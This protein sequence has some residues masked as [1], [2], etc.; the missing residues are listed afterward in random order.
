MSVV[1]R[2]PNHPIV[3]SLDKDRRV[4]VV[5]QRGDWL[6]VVLPAWAAAD[7]DS[8]RP[9]SWRACSGGWTGER[10]FVDLIR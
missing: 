3:A 4:R 8:L 10:I 2:V 1:G 5:G 9:G 6:V 7:E